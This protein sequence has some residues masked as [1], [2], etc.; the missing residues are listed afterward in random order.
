LKGTIQY[1]M[2]EALS[3]KLVTRIVKARVA[4]NKT[5]AE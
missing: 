2:D 4:L 5:K 3:K 1:P